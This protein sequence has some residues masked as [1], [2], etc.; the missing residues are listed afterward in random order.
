MQG[1]RPHVVPALVSALLLVVALGHHPY[2][3]YTFLRWVVCLTAILVVWVAWNSTHSWVGWPFAGVAILFNPL[4][5]VYLHRSTWRPIDIACA[6]AFVGSVSLR[7]STP[8][9]P[10]GQVPAGNDGG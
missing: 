7:R 10:S 3:F 1:T 5:P 8:E 9:P 4:A 6:I 2:G